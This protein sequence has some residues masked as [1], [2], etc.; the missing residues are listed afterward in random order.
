MTATPH[1][2][3]GVPDGTEAISGVQTLSRSY[4]NSAG[5][6]VETDDYF[7]LSGVT[8][9]TSTLHRHGRHQLLRHDLRLRRRRPASRVQRR[10]APSRARSST[11][12]AG[13]RAPGWGPTTRRPRAAGRRANNTSPSNMVELTADVYDGGGVGDGNLT[14]ETEYPGG[15]AAARVTD[16]YYDWRDRLVASKDGVQSS[17]DS[18]THR[19]ITYYTLDNLGEVTADAALRRRRRDHH[20][21]RRRAD[22]ARRQLLRAQTVDSYDDQGRVYQTQEYSVDPTSGAVSTYALTTNYYYDHRG[23]L[24]EE[25]DPGGLVTKTIYDGAGR[26]DG[27]LHDRRRRR[28]DLERCRQRDRR[29]RY[30]SRWKRYDADGN[31]I[32]TIDAPALPRRDGDRGAGQRDDGAEVA[33]LLRG[34]L[35]RRGQ[36]ADG[37]RRT[38]A[39]TAAALHAAVQRAHRIGHGAGDADRLQRRRLRRC[40]HRPARHRHQGLLRRPRPANERQSRTTPT[41]RRRTTPTRRRSTATTATATR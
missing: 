9:S 25:A 7:N 31:V 37:R 16:N 5:Q 22:G 12:R 14:Q 29:Q 40:H 15:G 30:W 23:E 39:P 38:W 4:T 1:L 3:G 6:V 8:Y 20:Q 36:P 18:T 10:R 11:A 27:G 32:E 19:P 28:H 17:E 35:L 2:T 41:A 13:G 26:V 34:G 33:R 24:I 21:Q